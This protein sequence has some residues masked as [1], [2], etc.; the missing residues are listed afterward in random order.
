[1]LDTTR[2]TSA[3][4]TAAVNDVKASGT[5]DT[6]SAAYPVEESQ[7]GNSGGTKVNVGK[8]TAGSFKKNQK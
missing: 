3:L 8:D 6:A 2:S 7:K 4:D 1:M 5:I